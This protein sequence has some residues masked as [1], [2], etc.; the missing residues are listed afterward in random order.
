MAGPALGGTRA[1]KCFPSFFPRRRFFG[2]DD[3]LDV[4]LSEISS[5]VQ[6]KTVTVV[7]CVLRPSPRTHIFRVEVFFPFSLF[8]GLAFRLSF[9]LRTYFRYLSEWD[10]FSDFFGAVFWLAH[11]Y[12]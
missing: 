9:H 4:L 5:Q 12:S 7:S 3:G 8:G 1:A 2:G 11:A 6:H 10:H